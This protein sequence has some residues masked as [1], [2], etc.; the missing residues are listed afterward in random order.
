[1]ARKSAVEKPVKGK[2]KKEVKAAPEEDSIQNRLARVYS[3]DLDDVAKKFQ[4]MTGLNKQPRIS[5]G[6]LMMDL[7]LGGKGLVPGMITFLGPEASA[8]STAAFTVLRSSIEAK[9]PI[10]FYFDAENAVDPNYTAGI[11]RVKSMEEAFGLRDEK[12]GKWIVPPKSRYSD[13][14]V[15][16]DVFKPMH[17]ILRSIPNK[18]YRPERDEWFL[19]FGREKAEMAKMKEMEL[20]HDP[21]LYTDTGMYWCSVGD[22]DAAQA[23]FFIDSLPALVT[24]EVDE[25]ESEGNALALEARSFS[26]Y[27]KRVTGRLRKKASMLVCVNQLRDAPMVR[28]GPKYTEPGGNALKY[29]CVSGDTLI[30]TDKGFL[31]AQEV[32]YLTDQ[33]AGPQGLETAQGYGFQGF[34]RTGVVTLESGHTLRAALDHAVLSYHPLDGGRFVKLK[35]L[36]K[37]EYVAVKIGSDIWADKAP[38]LPK[39]KETSYKRSYRGNGSAPEIM[40]PQVGRFLG[41]HVGDGSCRGSS[42]TFTGKHE[43]CVEYSSLL[44][45]IFELEAA[46]TITQK[47]NHSSLV[48]NNYVIGSFLRAVDCEHYGPEKKVPSLILRSPRETVLAFLS[49]LVDADG[50]VGPGT[51]SLTSVSKRLIEQ[52]QVLLTNL[53]IESRIQAFHPKGFNVGKM[54]ERWA[55]TLGIRGDSARL[56]CEIVPS[57]KS[58]NIQPLKGSSSP[59]LGFPKI[60]GWRGL[61]PHVQGWISTYTEGRSPS[62]YML[63]SKRDFLYGKSDACKTPQQRV[64]TRAALDQVYALVDQ[65]DQGYRWYKVKSVDLNH[66]KEM[67]FDGEMPVTHSMLTNGIVSH[68]SSNRTMMTPRVPPPGWDRDSENGGVCVEESVEGEDGGGFDYYAFK[69]IRNIKNKWGTPFRKGMCRVWIE[70]KFG[71]ARGFD[72]VYDAWSFYSALG[73]IEGNRKKTFRINLKETSGGEYTWESFKLIIL[74]ETKKSGKLR[75]R[76]VD[77]G[78]PPVKLIELGHKMLESGRADELYGKARHDGTGSEDGEDVDD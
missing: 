24:E 25:Q 31:P 14:N 15:I 17:T 55:Y 51:V 66:P 77:L 69:G 38:L 59:K 3:N 8:K 39:I 50:Y 52:V 42:V 40:T 62:A 63:R 4:L 35:K 60:F 49:G 10:N 22:D 34:K 30:S 7:V 72:P 36:S 43:E 13:A 9:I 1:M 71:K 44:T 11:L 75:T 73:V 64:A 56:F 26:K 54:R 2:A 78:V 23:I 6:L 46:I 41:L 28:Y 37:K 19:V 21:K 18:V 70:D 20:K 65:Y 12:T 32:Q 45:S 74:A 29:F 61:N 27:V 76:A 48:F 33:I 16:E 5:S 68:N 53:G 67:T 47:D 58:S 57:L